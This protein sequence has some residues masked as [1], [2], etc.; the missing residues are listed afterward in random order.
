MT[1]L[2]RAS[3]IGAGVL[4]MIVGLILAFLSIESIGL[5]SD[6][7]F[8]LNWPLAVPSFIVLATIGFTVAL[9]THHPRWFRIGILSTVLAF[10]VAL[11]ASFVLGSAAAGI[12]LFV[13]MQL[14]LPSILSANVGSRPKHPHPSDVRH[15]PRQELD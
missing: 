2:R 7:E 5:V 3:A 11:V 8:S 12:L 1:A 6:E 9:V 10:S 14:V 15:R 4:Q 13:T